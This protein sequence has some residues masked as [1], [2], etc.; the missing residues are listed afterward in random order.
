MYKN[1]K[2]VELNLPN[3]GTGIV[4]HEVALLYMSRLV[5][6]YYRLLDSG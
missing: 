3:R 5:R 1:K 2:G 4:R 6:Y